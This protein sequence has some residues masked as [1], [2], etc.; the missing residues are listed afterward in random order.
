MAFVNTEGKTVG[1]GVEWVLWWWLWWWWWVMGIGI[2]KL[3]FEN[4]DHIQQ[5]FCADTIRQ[6]VTMHQ[7]LCNI[8]YRS[9][10]IY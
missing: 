7:A 5:L 8:Q 10:N 9:K 2:R 6:H 3:K 1:E 4:C